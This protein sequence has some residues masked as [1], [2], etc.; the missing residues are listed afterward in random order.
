M[1]VESVVFKIIYHGGDAKALAY[2]ALQ[3]AH[4]GN[5]TEADEK[6]KEANKTLNKAHLTQTELIQ[7][8]INGEDVDIS[9][10][11]VHAQDHLMTAI[12]E[13]S[14]IEQMM[15]LLK[16]VHHLEEKMN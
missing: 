3:L 10:L 9:L 1:D 12:S 15:K 13:M 2:E 5:F 4:D 16:R 6:M 14:L 8:E 11:V 7:A